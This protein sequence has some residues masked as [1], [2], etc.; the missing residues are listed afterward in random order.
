MNMRSAWLNQAGWGDSAIQLAME[1]WEIYT[2]FL[3]KTLKEETIL[4]S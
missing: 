3:S 2:Q 4:K 1:G